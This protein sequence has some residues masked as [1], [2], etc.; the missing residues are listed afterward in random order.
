MIMIF[1]ALIFVAVHLSVG[2]KLK[3]L[4]TNRPWNIAHRGAS[5]VLPEHTK[6]AH[7]LAV[8]QG[9]D[10]IEC[11]LCLTQDLVPV[12]IHESWLSRTTDAEDK[13]PERE[14]TRYIDDMLI[15][16]TDIFSVDLTLTELKTLR[17]HQRSGSRDPNYDGQFEIV[18]LEEYIQIAQ[19]A[20]RTVG[21]Y[22]ETKQPIW[23]NNLEV[24][25]NADT[26]F[27]QIIVDV[28]TR[29]SYTSRDDPCFLQSFDEE[30]LRRFSNITNLPL[31]MLMVPIVS[32]TS[33][34]SLA[35]LA[36]F[37]YGIGTH[38]SMIVGVDLD[39]RVDEVTNLTQRAHIAGLKVH[40]WTFANNNYAWDYMHDP[41]GEY[42]Y[43][44][45]AGVD[46][47]FTDFPWTLNNYL[48]LKYPT[49]CP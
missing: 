11:D 34:E 5:G 29:Y 47:L 4:P 19:G 18:T 42:E 40:A 45:N 12:C 30:S 39:N 2:L 37:C 14:T 44:V 13:F 28:L 24:V 25:Q 38:K 10:I 31:V 8:D 16:V 1:T 23:V 32:D 9:A 15:D 41:H 3:T 35:E 6:E 43:Y 17:V 33:D 27:E 48:R 49:S 46:G 21:I 20:N 36:E 22:P 26:T 7:Q